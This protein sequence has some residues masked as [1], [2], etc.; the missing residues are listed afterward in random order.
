M[1]EVLLF[2]LVPAIVIGT[3]LYAVLAEMRHA[4]VRRSRWELRAVRSLRLRPVRPP[5]RPAGTP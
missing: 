5:F 4:R 1:S 3:I 2:T